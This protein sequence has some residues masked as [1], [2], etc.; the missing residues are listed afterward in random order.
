MAPEA[1]LAQRYVARVLEYKVSRSVKTVQTT[2]QTNV[3]TTVY[4]TQTTVY[5][6][7]NCSI[8]GIPKRQHAP[9][10]ARH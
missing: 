9:H 5:T 1:F 3:Q 8:Q 7:T 6:T 4:I 2:V 10:G